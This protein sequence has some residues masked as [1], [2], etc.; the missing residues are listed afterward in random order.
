MF[1][2]DF[3]ILSTP[4]PEVVLV[5]SIAAMFAGSFIAIFQ[6]NIKRMLAYSSVAQ[7]GYIT[8]GFSLASI[9]GLTGSLVHI[10]NHAMM[11]GALF[12]LVGGIAL[13][14]GSVRLK[15][16]AGIGREMPWTMAG[17]V[18]AGASM[19]GVPGTVGFVSKWYLALGALE[20]GAWWIVALLVISSLLVLAYM[21]RVVEVAYF[22]PRPD[23]AATL[24]DP[25]KIMLLMAWLLIAGCVYFGI[26]TDFTLGTAR[27]AANALIGTAP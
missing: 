4:V 16:M 14:L 11:K 12:M 10:F 22:R 26:S 7:I 24:Q 25:P 23:G 9:D 2:F 5:V 6:D 1:G 19:L 21:G 18:I 8:L 15:D 3:A 17:F 20:F 27:D 13:Q